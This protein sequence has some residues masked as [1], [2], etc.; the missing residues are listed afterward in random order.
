MSAERS[1]LPAL[2]VVDNARKCPWHEELREEINA[3]FAAR[4]EQ[5]GR[6][7][8]EIVELRREVRGLDSRLDTQT[9]NQATLAT[10]LA[11]SARTVSNG[12]MI[13]GAGG[14]VVGLYEIIRVA[15]HAFGWW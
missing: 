3:R 6:V 12:G 11:A 5:D 8:A 13:A 9:S 10:T 1:S 7:L 2:E 15:G 14:G 4:D